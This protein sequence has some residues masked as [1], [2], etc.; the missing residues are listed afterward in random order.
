MQPQPIEYTQPVQYTQPG[1]I[2]QPNQYQQPAMQFNA[3]PSAPVMQKPATSPMPSDNGGR[4]WVIAGGLHIVFMVSVFIY[5]LV[6]AL[7]EPFEYIIDQDFSGQLLYAMQTGT[8]YFAFP[9]F[10][11]SLMSVYMALNANCSKVLA[12]TLPAI[13]HAITLIL[14]ALIMSSTADVP[15]SDAWDEIFGEDFFE[16]ILPELL[17]HLALCTFSMMLISIGNDE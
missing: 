13:S 5:S 3:Q 4:G 9:S 1:V 16:N 10:V 2:P 8:W 17:S 11:V 14:W 15:F 7:F 12:C 6:Y